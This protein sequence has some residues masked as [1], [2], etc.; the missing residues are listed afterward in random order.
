MTTTDPQDR[1]SFAPPARAQVDP[2]KP[3][4]HSLSAGLIIHRVGQ[5]AYDFTH[6]ARGFAREL[7]G[8]MNARL[9]AEATTFVYQEILGQH[10][11]MHWLVHMKTPS[12]YGR[13]LQMVDHDKVFQEIYQRDRLP[14]RGGGNWERIFLQGSFRE[15]V[16]VPQH[17]FGKEALDELDPGR[18]V[19]PA[20][21]QIRRGSAPLLDS[22]SAGAIVLRT[23]QAQ[24]G[25][26][27]VARHFLHE[28]QSYVNKAVAGAVTSAQF[29]EIW[30]TQD[31]LHL[32]LH[33]RSFDDYQ[34]LCQLESQDSGLKDLLA[35]P[36]VN[37]GGKPLGWGSLFQEASISDTVLLPLS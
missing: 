25:A 19:P 4:I 2:D 37:I 8:Y 36:R 13:L 24:Y 11:R 31:R 34:V 27:D 18:F 7:Q 21:H 35:K 20:R 14:E 3:I 26:R 16:M 17:G 32:M 10:G 1:W 22:S 30:G 15:N 23:T 6:E 28:W 29:E 33:L 12:D 9:S 5:V